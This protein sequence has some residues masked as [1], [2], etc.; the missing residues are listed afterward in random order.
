MTVEKAINDCTATYNPNYR[1]FQSGDSTAPKFTRQ[2]LSERIEATEDF[3]ELIGP[4]ARDVTDSGLPESAK[5]SLR[6]FIAKKAKV[7]VAS[8]IADV[9]EFSK[10]DADKD[11]FHLAVAR[12]VVRSYG[13]ENIL[14]EPSGLTWRW[15]VCGVWRPIHDREIR[16]KIIEI[17][18]NDEITKTIVDSILALVKDIIFKP[19]HRF[20]IDQETINC[21]NGEL[22]WG[23]QD[24]VLRPHDREHFR[25]TQIPV[26]YD[27]Q[28]RAPGFE[29]FLREIFQSDPEAEQKITIICEM[30]GYT[31]LSSC[32]FEKFI[33]LIGPGANGK[34]VLMD[35]LKAL[36]G[37]DNTAAVRPDE[38]ED[39]FKRG[40]L[41]HKLLNLV[42]EIRE[43]AEIHDAELKSITS[44]ETITG[45]HKF[46]DP[47]SFTP[48][49]TCW[50]GTN[51]MPHT[52]DFSEAIT[53]RASI[54][55]FNRIFQESEQD[56]KLKDKLKAELSGVLNLALEGVAGILQRG[57]FST[58]E[59]SEAIKRDWRLESD[60]V[61][62]FIEEE[63]ELCLNLTPSATVYTHY[64][65]WANEAGVKRSLNRKN[66]TT[67]VQRFG[68]T[69]VKGVSGTRMLSGIRLRQN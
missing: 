25:T 31:L 55:P 29:Q 64:Q 61:A 69:L 6:K 18:G 46:K 36:V 27:A 4:I 49:C 65:A 10:I 43:G 47:F 50:F 33:I 13:V 12:E 45:E 28:A 5:L 67:R 66:F 58:T 7:N 42:T 59:S 38:F 41:H 63:C 11:T 37:S 39:R 54:I 20:D 44:G 56:K 30:M 40:Y 8:L 15:N 60:Q 9:K 1:H 21:L 52:R 23:G 22:H 35:I 32:R 48:I 53:R 17:A 51:H 19:D 57:Q 34:S 2:E 16:Q 68:V 3:D 26:V 24:W 62:Q 14:S